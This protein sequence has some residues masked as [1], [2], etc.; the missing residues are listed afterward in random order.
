MQF[1]QQNGAKRKDRLE[2]PRT[3]FEPGGSRLHRRLIARILYW[4]EVNSADEIRQ[5]EPLVWLTGLFLIGVG[6]Y[7]AAPQEPNALVLSVLL[8]GSLILLW[9][10]RAVDVRFFCM[11]GISCLLGG[12]FVATLHTN[13]L[14]TKIIATKRVVALEGQITAYEKRADGSARLTID[15]LIAHDP[16]G[17]GEMPERIR[18]RVLA[19]DF[20]AK[21]GERLMFRAEIGPPPGPVMPGG[22]DFARDMFFQGI[23]A[24][25]FIYGKPKVLV[26]E[27]DSSLIADLSPTRWRAAIS[28]RILKAFEANGYPQLAG[29]AAALL[30][31]ETGNIEPEIRE[32]FI[33][34]GLAHVLAISG[35]HMALVVTFVIFSLRAL[36]ALNAAMALH[37]PIRKLAI[38]AGLATGLAYF[39]LSGG[40]VSATRAFIMVGIMATALL[41]ARRALSVRNI[42][43]ACL[44]ILLISP[45]AMVGP[46][47][48]MS[49]AA[50]LSL[51]AF[52][53]YWMGPLVFE[54]ENTP[55]PKRMLIH[56]RRYFRTLLITSLLAGTASGLFAAYH[57]H[58]IAPLGLL[59][60]LVGVPIF[61]LFVMPFGFFGLLLMPFGYEALPF[62]GMAFALDMIVKIAENISHHATS[63][64]GTGLLN[65]GAFL[66]LCV[67]FVMLC[68]MKSEL[69]IF[70]AFTF[71]IGFWQLPKVDLPDI[72]ISED[73]KTVA[74][75]V[76]DEELLVSGGRAGRFELKVWRAALGL[77][78]KPERGAPDALSCDAHGCIF[79]KNGRIIAHMKHPS[80][81]YED[82]RMADMIISPL[83]APAFCKNTAVVIDRNTLLKG[84]AHGVWLKPDGVRSAPDQ[85]ARDR[86]AEKPNVRDQAARKRFII[87]ASIPSVLRPWHQHYR[88]ATKS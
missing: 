15:N 58:R 8:I 7:F 52:A 84:G 69:R 20:T 24:T 1:D 50:T 75:R 34:S 23:G 26:D 80:G 46:S 54:G 85:T 25:G 78:E 27:K 4:L 43:L 56:F 33:A 22:Y 79:E 6:L 73:G 14:D 19:K 21:P 51:V 40:S 49:F 3:R 70:L 62:K 57:F 87:K 42:A 36:F 10:W 76:R 64:A 16:R 2:T 59:A 41:F 53:P 13:R 37:Y 28:K 9:R 88:L 44:L 45:Y 12:F 81:F 67:S 65:D 60:N 11:A 83:S 39:L 74:M 86:A 47:F 72:L 48:Q 38:L 17:T 30:V 71:A 18:V 35:L 68:V 63:Y 5:A 29:V 66:L 82:C 55:L 61:S 32:V 31:G 77:P